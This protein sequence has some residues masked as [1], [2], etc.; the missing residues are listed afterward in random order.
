MLERVMIIAGES[1][2]ELYG[3][4]LACSLKSLH[5]NIKIVGVGGSKMQAAGVELISYISGAFGITEALQA[6]RQLRNT[7]NKVITTL[8]TFKPQI[9]ILIDYPDFNIRLAKKAKKE[10]IKILYYVSPQIWAWRQSRIK[11]LRKLVDKMAVIL[12]FE[13]EIYLK[14]GV[15]CEFVGHPALDEIKKTI[16]ALGYSDTDIDSLQLKNRVRSEVSIEAS[17]TVIC[18]MP[19]SRHHEI[20]NLLPI[21]EDVISELNNMNDNFTF[22]IPVAPNLDKNLLNLF[23][24]VKK[25]YP[26]KCIL[27][28]DPIK[29]LIA[30]DIAVIASGTATLQSALL[31][32]PMVVIYKLSPLSYFLGRLLIRIKHFSLVN[33][34]LVKSTS[35]SPHYR[36]K[37]LLQ[38]EVNKENITKEIIRI[39]EDDSYRDNL[40]SL[41]LKIR[42]LFINKT[43]SQRVAELVEELYKG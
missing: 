16:K 33:I 1:S 15:P 41:L 18:L 14:D 32:V 21:M 34:L 12:P 25:R 38:E 26:D 24:S 20:R 3:S 10:N 11:T 28:N 31:G 4:L 42:M 23:D 35:E 36:I 30:S 17:K 19:G 27:S 6:Y 8:R 43:P 29:S 40:K 9:L 37:E 7:F 13:E 5:P 2:G 22:I 39:S